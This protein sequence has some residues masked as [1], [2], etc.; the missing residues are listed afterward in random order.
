GLGVAYW[1]TLLGVARQATA[2]GSHLDPATLLNVMPVVA[3]IGFVIMFI[4]W[5][6]LLRRGDS[7]DAAN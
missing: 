5:L 7:A 6:V 2:P 4:A 3:A 1:V